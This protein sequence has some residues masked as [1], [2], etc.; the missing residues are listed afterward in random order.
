MAHYK[1]AVALSVR[2]KLQQGC[3]YKDEHL[4][5]INKWAGLVCQGAR[6][7]VKTLADRLLKVFGVSSDV[8]ALEKP[9]V[10][11]RLDKPTTG[12]LLVARS[13]VAARHISQLFADRKVR[14]EYYAVVA[15]VPS[16]AAGI[17][18]GDKTRQ[19]QRLG[20]QMVGGGLVV[21]PFNETSSTD[22]PPTDKAGRG[23]DCGVSARATPGAGSAHEDKGVDHG[24]GLQEGSGAAATHRAVSEA[25][26][27]TRFEVVES[28]G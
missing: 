28:C 7:G 2:M 13:R 10:L 6:P 8:D 23:F 1:G 16:H 26:S 9:Q 17:I 3:L 27:R 19:H 21:V 12:V 14:K 24:V 15:G 11:H 5:A 20:K 22:R 4:L 18:V 25:G